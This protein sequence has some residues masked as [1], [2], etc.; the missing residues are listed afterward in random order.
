M[1][2]PADELT[3]CPRTVTPPV[4]SGIQIEPATDY[5]VRPCGVCQICVMS[6]RLGQSAGAAQHHDQGFSGWG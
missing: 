5:P 1:T 2:D 6:A 4:M 3:T